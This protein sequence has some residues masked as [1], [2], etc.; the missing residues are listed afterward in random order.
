MDSLLDYILSNKDWLFSG[1]GV[2]VLGLV[3][4]AFLNKANKKSKIVRGSLNIQVGR[5]IDI[6]I[7]NKTDKEII[8]QIKQ[9]NKPNKANSA[10]AKSCAA[11]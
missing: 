11:D 6:N 8:S 10:D 3:I 7:G 2:A 4:S 1:V 5:D 9:R